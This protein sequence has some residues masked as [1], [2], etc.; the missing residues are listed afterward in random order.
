MKNLSDHVKTKSQMNLLYIELV[1][2]QF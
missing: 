1:T 2:S